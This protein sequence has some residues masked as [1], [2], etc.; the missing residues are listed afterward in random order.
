VTTLQR[1]AHDVPNPATTWGALFYA[2]LVFALAWLAG[3]GV[4]L[5][6][7]RAAHRHGGDSHVQ[8]ETAFIVD[9]AQVGIYLLALTLYV[10]IVPSL[11]HLGTPLL[12]SVGVMSV[13][14]GIAAQHTLGNLVAGIAILL[15]RP[16]R[17]GDQLQ[18]SAPTGL[19]TGV[20]ERLTLGYTIL[21]T[22]DNRRVVVPN[23]L[24]ATQASVNLSSV[25]PRMAAVVPFTI[26][27]K[28]DID[29][30]RAI[31]VELAAAHPQVR[32][33]IGC[34]VTELGP[35]GVVLSLR[36]WCSSADATYQVRFD[37]L[38]RAKRRFEQAGIEIPYPTTNVI[39]GPPDDAR[40]RSAG[41]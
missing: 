39:I 41:A 32:E 28:T 4:R 22:F 7:R 34:P 21:R 13:V 1:L 19:E 3:H 16:F 8:A 5:A 11:R 27:Y 20:V 6:V 25:D 33:I 36:A 23:T 35:S 29:R 37:L 9:L 2:V 38:E 26:S 18:V 14:L 12:A 30:A 31:L 40:H 17:V 15:Y 10:H 24:M